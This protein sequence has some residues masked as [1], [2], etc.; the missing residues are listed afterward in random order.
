MEHKVVENDARFLGSWAIDTDQLGQLLRWSDASFY[1]LFCPEVFA[2]QQRLIP[3]SLIRAVLDSREVPVPQKPNVSD[4]VIAPLSHSLSQ[5]LIYDVLSG[6]Q[7]STQPELVGLVQGEAF[8][9]A[10]PRRIIEVHLRRGMVDR[11]E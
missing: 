10:P 11:P 8:P 2:S 4:Q 3:A 9:G 7:G 6:W 5:F 1:V